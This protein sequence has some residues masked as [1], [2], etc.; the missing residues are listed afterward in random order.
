MIE[1]DSWGYQTGVNAEIQRAVNRAAGQEP[2]RLRSG[3][4]FAGAPVA[5]PAGTTLL[6][7]GAT[8][9]GVGEGQPLL[10]S[11]GERVRVVGGELLAWAPGVT[12][13][14]GELTR[15]RLEDCQFWASLARGVDGSGV[16]GQ[17]R[18]CGFGMR[19]DPG[20]LFQPIRVVGVNGDATFWKVRDC[21]VYNGNGDCAAVEFAD[22]YH[23]TITGTNFEGN[24]GRA[25]LRLAGMF[26]AHLLGNWFERNAG[27][28]QVELANSS[29][30]QTGNPVVQSRGNWWNLDVAGNRWAFG[31]TGRAAVTFDQEA[32]TGWG[33]MQV[34]S[35]M[36]NVTVGAHDLVGYAG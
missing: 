34:A 28:A 7:D 27:P 30:N 1:I 33:G 5:M 15:L 20:P 12:G 26:A 10:R 11:L 23:V 2:V 35:S 22:G 31:I 17:I 19:G 29:D 14:V 18:D 8:L 24:R 16:H 13:V 36:T 32:G 4:Y 9:V 21:E 25:A 6:M 3:T